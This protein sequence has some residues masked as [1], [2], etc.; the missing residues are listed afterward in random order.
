MKITKLKCPACGGDLKID[1]EHQN[2]AVCEYCN[3][4]FALE[5]DH[6]KATLS[7]QT[8][9]QPPR[10]TATG[11][12][13]GGWKRLLAVVAGLLLIISPSAISIYH[14]WQRAHSIPRTPAA[15]PS[16]TAPPQQSALDSEIY[17]E[18]N[19][20]EEQEQE[21]APLAGALGIL[22]ETVF[23]KP[24]D[25]IT[26][27]ELAKIQWIETAS[28]WDYL[29]I[30]YSFS[31]PLE[32]KNAELT[33]LS[34]SDDLSLGKECLN[35]FTGLK[36]L[37]IQNH[38]TQS[39]IGGLSLESIGCY[40]SSPEEI[41]ALCT[42]VSNMKEIRL[43]AGAETLDGLDRFQNLET[44]YIDNIDSPDISQIVNL[45]SLK[46]LTL[47][48]CDSLSDF[49]VF[50]VMDSLEE[51]DVES[52]NLKSLDFLPAMQSLKKLRVADAGILTL[53]GLEDL[54]ELETLTIEDCSNLKNM[55]AVENL[56]G[57]QELYLEL[58]YDCPQPDLSK[59]T[60]LSRLGLSQFEDCAF[61]SGMTELTSLSLSNCALENT[62]SLSNLVKMEELSLR[63]Y[64]SLGQP[65]GFLYGFP[66]LKKLNLAGVATYDDI[67]GIFNIPTL[68][69]LNMNGMECEIAFDRI[70]DN[71]SLT[72]LHMDGLLLYENVNVSG[73]GGIYSVGW[74]D[75]TLDDHTGFLSHF[76]SL[77]ILSIAEN[78]LTD[79]SFAENLPLLEQIDI[80]DNFVTD[81]K[82]LSGLG[83]LKA[84]TCTGNSV[85]N[86]R[87]LD[88]KV[89]VISE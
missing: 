88:D 76:P 12:E 30:G 72:E 38:L 61:L 31:N 55:E 23:G 16:F 64:S 20:P 2:F 3:S 4:S 7:G 82:P 73:G 83:K 89:T 26:D 67:S 75:V 18:E 21:K 34:L 13:A 28:D 41:A 70:K 24:A 29:Q 37:N 1:N 8:S 57:L 48:Y 87:V 44:L 43:N 69:Y 77:A 81:L 68:A 17:F 56:T 46:S 58:P 74:D 86:Y 15:T 59:L 71:P 62:V 10:N 51:L 32:E 78:E 33:W 39:D 63:N 50:R 49:S 79:I 27:S 54:T 42:D 80:S 40:A 84:V 19:A 47:E 66:S 25:Q 36:K 9:W 60:Q 11:W 5:W 45:P 85:S 52:E 14:R 65:I 6:E 35:R 53:S 22:A